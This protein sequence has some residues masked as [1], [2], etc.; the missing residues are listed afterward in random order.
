MAGLGFIFIV[1]PLSVLLFVLLIYSKKKSFGILFLGFWGGIIGIWIL[2][3]ILKPFYTK[4]ILDKSDFYGEYIIDRNYFPGKQADWQYNHFRFEIKK[5]DSIYFY[6]TEGANIKET[7]TGSIQTKTPFQS[8]RLM[9]N[10]ESPTHHVVTSNPTIYR[11]IWDFF[12][13]FNSPKF[14]NM[15]FRKGNWKEIE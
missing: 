13:V 5:N 6:V 14:N 11:E 7:Y 1:L 10:M 15:Y 8:A 4:K 2:S 12:L 9:I 3:A